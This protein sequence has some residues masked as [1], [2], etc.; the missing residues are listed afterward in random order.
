MIYR[1][2]QINFL[3]IFI[4]TKK[5][6]NS[7]QKHRIKSFKRNA[8]IDELFYKN[9]HK[10]ELDKLRSSLCFTFVNFNFGFSFNFSNYELVSHL[11]SRKLKLMSSFIEISIYATLLL[12]LIRY[13]QMFS[14]CEINF[15]LN[16]WIIFNTD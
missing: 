10:E 1:D 8:L 4:H 3:S 5:K 7:T 14:R 16:F 9:K 13:G 2:E 11:C 15:S 6:T 12:S